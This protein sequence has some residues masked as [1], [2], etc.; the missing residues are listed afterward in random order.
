M[1]RHLYSSMDRLETG[2]ALGAIGNT[3]IFIFQ[4]GYKCSQECLQIHKNLYSS[5]DRLETRDIIKNFKNAKT[6]IFQYG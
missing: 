6:F 5:M 1:Q 2:S 4:Y 3:I